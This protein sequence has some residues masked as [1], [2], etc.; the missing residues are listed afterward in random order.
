L[1][2]LGLLTG[3]RLGELCQLYLSDFEEHN[4]VHCINVTDD[5]EGQRVKNAN[6]KRLVL[7]R[8]KLIEL[9][10]LRYVQALRRRGE[11]WLF[12]ELSA[13]GTAMLKRRQRSPQAARGRP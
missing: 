2:P 3:A 11:T 8:D 1:M 9:G 5:D 6:A 10:L 13:S 12:P 4:G 7:I